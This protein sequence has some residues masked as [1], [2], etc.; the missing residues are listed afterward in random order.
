MSSPPQPPGR[1]L[2]KKNSWPSRAGIGQKSLDAELIGSPTFAGSPHGSSTLAR[3]DT[4][5][6]IPRLP[7]RV[8]AMKNVFPSRDDAG[9]PSVYGV[10]KFRSAPGDASSIRTA[11]PH[12]AK[13]P[14]CAITPLPADPGL[15]AAASCVVH[16]IAAAAN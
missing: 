5:M 10:L 6:S 7:G 15:G 16:P 13:G 3:R 11:C 2:T 4:Q 12:G 14:S 8:D 1:L 9:Q